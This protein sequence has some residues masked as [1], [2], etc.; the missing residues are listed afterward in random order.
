MSCSDFAASSDL[1]VVSLVNRSGC[2]RERRR[3]A[4]KMGHQAL[5]LPNSDRVLVVNRPRVID[6]GVVV[7]EHVFSLGDRGACSITELNAIGRHARKIRSRTP[8]SLRSVKFLGAP[9][10]QEGQNFPDG[11]L[12]GQ[13]G[14]DGRARESA[15]TRQHV[16]SA[17]T[18]ISRTRSTKRCGPPRMWHGFEAP[19]SGLPAPPRRAPRR[20]RA[21]DWRSKLRR[22][23]AFEA[24]QARGRECP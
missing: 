21:Q 19:G 14:S 17:S 10:I 22:P 9:R 6:R 13:A 18:T 16:A 12:L 24:P 2:P 11:L 4:W 5:P 20:L 3:R 1:A 23:A 15:T 7:G 8:F